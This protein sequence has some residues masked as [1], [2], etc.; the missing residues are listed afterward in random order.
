MVVAESLITSMKIKDIKMLKIF[1]VLK[2]TIIIL[3]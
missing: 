1:K 2:I 3:C